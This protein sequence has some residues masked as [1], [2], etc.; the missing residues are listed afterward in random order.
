MLF[1][2]LGVLPGY[3]GDSR[4]LGSALLVVLMS[5]TVYETFAFQLSSSGL[6]AAWVVA[7]SAPAAQ[8]QRFSAVVVV[9]AF[10]AA[11]HAGVWRGDNASDAVGSGSVQVQQ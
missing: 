11:P 1:R 2:F 3:F 7:P 5:L 10:S 6:P 4:E 9:A 8:Q